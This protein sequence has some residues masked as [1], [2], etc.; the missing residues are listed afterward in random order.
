MAHIHYN[1]QNVSVT[2]GKTCLEKRIP[3]VS[4]STDHIA[5]YRTVPRNTYQKSTSN[6]NESR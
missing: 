4:H 2:S 1:L 5:S 6:C 3:G